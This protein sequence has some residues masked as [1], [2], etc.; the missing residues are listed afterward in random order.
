M[1]WSYSPGL[2]AEFLEAN[3]SDTEQSALLSTTPMPDQFYSHGKP[4]EHSSISR[5]GMTCEHLTES[6]GEEL[7]TWF[8]AG[9]HA[10]T[11][12][13]PEKA[14][15]LTENDQ[16][17]GEKWRGWLAK[18]DQDSCSWKTAQLSLLGDLIESSVILPRSGMTRGGLLWELPMLGRLTSETGFGFWPTP[19]ASDTSSRNVKYQQGGMPLSLAVKLWPTPTGGGKSKTTC[20]GDWGGSGSRKK[21]RGMVSE[22]ELFGPLN[23]DWVEWLMGWPIGHTDLKPSETAKSR[24]AELL[25]GR[26]LEAH[27]AV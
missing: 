10:K 19:V 5:F 18:F 2:V 3:Y 1:S 27:E 26:L 15:E 6:L 11:F 21:L 17:C 24:N 23:P 13:S 25:L 7:L 8:L 20:L 9:F 14:Q 16:D 22:K 4:T 12:P